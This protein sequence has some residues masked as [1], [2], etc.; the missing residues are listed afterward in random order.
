VASIAI[1]SV[2]DYLLL[3]HSELLTATLTL[4]DGTIVSANKVTWAVTPASVATVTAAG[5]LSGRSAGASTATASF[6]GA[7]TSR[8]GRVVPDFSGPWTGSVSYLRCRGHWCGRHGEYQ[9]G[10]GPIVL[11]LSQDQSSVSG[12]IHLDDYSTGNVTGTIA[13]DGTLTLQGIYDPRDAYGWIV[14]PLVDWRSTVD[15]M[16][17]LVGTFTLGEVDTFQVDVDLTDVH[18]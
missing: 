16:G 17:H 7:S 6:Q 10:P 8:Q 2:P 15:S 3:G 18:H 5:I 1:A 14:N 4:G 13:L 9:P 11:T 12:A